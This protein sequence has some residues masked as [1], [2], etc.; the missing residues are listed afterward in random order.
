MISQYGMSPALVGLTNASSSGAMA[1]YLILVD[2][3][4][5]PMK[6]NYNKITPSVP[7]N[8]VALLGTAGLLFLIASFSG[9]GLGIPSFFLY[10]LCGGLVTL[11]QNQF[12]AQTTSIYSYSTLAP[13]A[14]MF[15]WFLF[16]IFSLLTPILY[17]I[18]P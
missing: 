13:I 17:G 14:H 11:R 9:A 3:L 8:F 2:K 18:S 5:K 12:M 4:S 7:F 1:L 16:A 6:K 10:D 15:R